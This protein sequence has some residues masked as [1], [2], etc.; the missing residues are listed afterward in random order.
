[1]ASVPW[2]R[3]HS[4]FGDVGEAAGRPPD[5]AEPRRERVD[6]VDAE[7]HERPTRVALAVSAPRVLGQRP[8]QRERRLGEHDAPE[9]AG[10]E[11]LAHP[12]RGAEAAERVADRQ[13]H[14]GARALVAHALGGLDGVGDRL[15]DE[16]V[17]AALRRRDR[18]LG[19]HVVGS[20]EQD[21]LHVRVL[22][23]RLQGGCGLAAV[24]RREGTAAFLVTGEAGDDA[25]AG[26]VGRRRHAGAP[27]A[28]ADERHAG[29][30]AAT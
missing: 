18:L 22:D 17:A 3:S 10:V 8:G 24:L 20:D 26:A 25:Q 7:L 11:Q 21:A 4:V 12:P 13:R 16:D 29:V 19:V 2:S 5:R 23:R 14:A 30:H 6:V 28:D 15:L 9:R 27:H 1:M